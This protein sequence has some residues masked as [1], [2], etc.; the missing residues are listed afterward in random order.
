MLNRVIRSA[1]LF[2][3]YVTM[4]SPAH[5]YLDPATGSIMIQALIGVVASWA[6]YSRTFAAKVRA[7][8]GRIR[9]KRK[10]SD[11]E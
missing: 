4:S 8:L 7:A 3:A 2:V 5:A 9:K 11:A 10:A 1:G 6:L